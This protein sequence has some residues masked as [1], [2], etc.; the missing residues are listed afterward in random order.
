MEF[1]VK[2]VMTK[3]LKKQIQMFSKE[4]SLSNFTV[5]KAPWAFLSPGQ[6]KQRRMKEEIEKKRYNSAT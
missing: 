3:D 4:Y 6:K 1:I 2:T 5:V